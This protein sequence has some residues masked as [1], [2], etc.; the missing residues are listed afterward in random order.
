MRIRISLEYVFKC[1]FYGF[2]P[3]EFFAVSIRTG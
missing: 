2:F 1:F 3:Y